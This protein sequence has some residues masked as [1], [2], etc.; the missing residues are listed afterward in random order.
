[1]M[2]WLGCAC[3]TGAS[4]VIWKSDLLAVLCFVWQST[5]LPQSWDDAPEN[6]SAFWG[7]WGWAT[8]CGAVL[9]TVGC[10]AGS[11]APHL[12]QKHPSHDNHG[13]LH[14][15]PGVPRGRPWVQHWTV[16]R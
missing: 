2:H 12:K 15:L 5:V 1:M 3:P 11:L 13:Y 4:S 14:T 10:R 7:H 6:V 8:L 16:P 9:G